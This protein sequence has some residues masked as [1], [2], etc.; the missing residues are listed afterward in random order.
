[1][2][3]SLS[4]LVR[5]LVTVIVSVLSEYIGV[6]TRVQ[7]CA[8]VS[9]CPLPPSPGV[10]VHFLCG[11]CVPSGSAQ[12]GEVQWAASGCQVPLFGFASVHS[13]SPCP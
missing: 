1:M 9:R 5:V 12:C 6:C 11:W 7:V 4:I 10:L 8:G 3:I 13:R 2:L